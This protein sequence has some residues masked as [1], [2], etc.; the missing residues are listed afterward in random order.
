MI[1]SFDSKPEG[2]EDGGTERA[3]GKKRVARGASARMKI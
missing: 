1:A 2:Y 3:S